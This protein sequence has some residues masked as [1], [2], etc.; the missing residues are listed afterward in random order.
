MLF[1]EKKMGIWLGHVTALI[2]ATIRCRMEKSSGVLWCRWSDP[3]LPTRSLFINFSFSQSKIQT[4]REGQAESET[5]KEASAVVLFL[6]LMLL[7]LLLLRLLLLLLMNG[8]GM[9]PGLLLIL[10]EL[11]AGK[12]PATDEEKH[13]VRSAVPPEWHAHIQQFGNL[14]RLSLIFKPSGSARTMTIWRV[15]LRPVSVNKTFFSAQLKT[16][17]TFFQFCIVQWNPG[18]ADKC[19]ETW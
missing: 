10:I 6:P 12:L 11:H 8:D 2:D 16:F 1:C 3:T 15:S 17:P 14:R 5:R 4:R 7:L 9:G 18:Y 19:R 13:P